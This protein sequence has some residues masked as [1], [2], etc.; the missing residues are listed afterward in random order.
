MDKD[1]SKRIRLSMIR[2][3][4]YAPFH[5]WENPEIIETYYKDTLITQ[6]KR[7]IAELKPEDLINITEENGYIKYDIDVVIN[8][9]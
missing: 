1:K 3:S 5:H 4:E 7:A 9:F 2:H 8:K 6:F